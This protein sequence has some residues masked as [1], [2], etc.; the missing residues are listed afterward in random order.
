MPAPT[1]SSLVVPGT[2]ATPGANGFKKYFSDLW[3]YVDTVIAAIFPFGTG[4]YQT[5]VPTVGGLTVG[6]G[7]TIAG[8]YTKHA[9]NVKGRVEIILGTGF[10][11]SGEVT[12]SLPV[13]PV[14]G[15]TQ[16]D[17][18]GRLGSSSAVYALDS[19]QL[20]VT[21]TAPMAIRAISTAAGML[22]QINATTPGTWLV[23]GRLIVNFDYEAAS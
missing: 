2:P 20:S 22:S 10:A 4:A 7:G 6:T 5:Y 23:G 3:T 21:A 19:A 8:R 13:E 11:F 16:A 14:S 15:Y 9:R 18:F 1:G 12:I 17:A